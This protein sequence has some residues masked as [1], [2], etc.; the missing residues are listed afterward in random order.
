MTKFRRLLFSLCFQW[1]FPVWLYALSCSRTTIIEHNYYLRSALSLWKINSLWGAFCL[2]CRLFSRR[3]HFS[4]SRWRKMTRKST[5]THHSRPRHREKMKRKKS[6]LY[7]EVVPST[8][9]SLLL[10]LFISIPAFA[11]AIHSKHSPP[12][13]H[14]AFALHLHSLGAAR[15]GG[16]SIQ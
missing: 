11:T 3:R 5:S 1:L 12:I 14:F 2:A 8:F 4:H 15:H 6:S 7:N 9:L 16:A 13:V 10:F